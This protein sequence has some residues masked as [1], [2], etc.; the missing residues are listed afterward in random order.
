[1]NKLTYG[2]FAS[3]L[4]LSIDVTHAA[5]VAEVFNGEMLGT[6]QRYFESV[7]GIP[8]ES[9]GDEHKFKVQGCDITA[10]VEGG[11][12]SK[13]RMELTPKCQADLTQFVGTFAPAPGKPLT[14]GAFSASSGGGLSYSASCLSMCGNAAD[15]SFYAHW[16]GPRAIGFREVLL[17]VVLA[18]DPA[19]D[20]ANQWE[21]QMRKAEGEDYV[22]ETRFNCDRKYDA[23]A[24]KAF[25][26]VQVSAVTIGTELKAS[27]C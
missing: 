26:K 22:M 17:E 6:N 13:L 15:P 3:A 5:S 14:V 25:E 21:A 18:S 19:L 1:M 11:T 24:Q 16:E 12:V 7:A 9:F 27:G 10:T 2:L 8:R 23:A 4:A 20:A